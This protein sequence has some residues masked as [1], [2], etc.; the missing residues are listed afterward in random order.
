MKNL[1][2]IS[3]ELGYEDVP[4]E[5]QEEVSQKI[6]KHIDKEALAEID[7]EFQAGK[8]ISYQS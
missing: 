8:K 3:K 1:S 4:K 5:V 2:K 6:S 7:E